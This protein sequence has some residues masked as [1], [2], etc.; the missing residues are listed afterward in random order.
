VLA[1][2]FVVM[3]SLPVSRAEELDPVQDSE[4]DKQEEP[5]KPTA[6]ELGE[7]DPEQMPLVQTGDVLILW[8]GDRLTG[9]IKGLEKGLLRFKTDPTGTINIEWDY[10]LRLL[11][12][13]TYQV[14]LESGERFYGKF[15]EPSEDGVLYVVGE[16]VDA[17]LDMP[18]VVR[19]R[20]IEAGIWKKIDGSLTIGLSYTKSSEVSQLTFAGDAIYKARKHQI[21]L[22][23]S[24]IVTQQVTGTT[25]RQDFVLSGRQFFKK[26]LFS[27]EAMAFQQND[28]LGIDLRVLTSGGIGRYLLQTNYQD[29]ALVGALA[30]NSEW[31]TDSSDRDRNLEAMIYTS[32]NIFRYRHPQTRLTSSLTIFPSL[33]DWGRVRVEFNSTLRNE[34]VTDFYWDLNLYL[35]YDNQPP[36]QQAS[37]SDYG[38]VTGLGWSF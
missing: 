21:G 6:R 34:I 17:E 37:A 22:T 5:A 11:S 36:D 16:E 27:T 9:D 3:G 28:E 38:I 31:V 29:L 32:Y 2:I 8:N 33:T 26:K 14:E 19:I 13:S 35:S 18:E 30:I 20:P 25:A 23:F 7:E 4:S 24:S 1:F 12:P 15:F 10:V